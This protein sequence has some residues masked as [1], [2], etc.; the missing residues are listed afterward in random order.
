MFQ[1]S[2]RSLRA[3]YQVLPFPGTEEA[4]SPWSCLP[5]EIKADIIQ[6]VIGLQ[7]LRTG[8]LNHMAV[9]R[10]WYLLTCQAV[11]ALV[12]AREVEGDFTGRQLS[13]FPNLTSLELFTNCLP[14]AECGDAMVGAMAAACPNLRRLRISHNYIDGGERK[15]FTE[16][17]LRLLFE[18][19][20][21]LE[22]LEYTFQLECTV[23]AEIANLTRLTSLTLLGIDECQCSVLQY[24]QLPAAASLSRLQSLTITGWTFDHPPEGLFYPGSALRVLDV[25]CFGL[26]SLTDSFSSLQN[27]EHLHVDAFELSSLPDLSTFTG[28]TY[29]SLSLSPDVNPLAVL[30]PSQGLRVLRCNCSHVMREVPEAVSAYTALRDLELSEVAITRLPDSLVRLQGLTRFSLRWCRELQEIPSFVWRLPS[31]QELVLYDNGG[32]GGVNIDSL[33]HLT[34]LTYLE[35]SKIAHVPDGCSRLRCL[36]QLT[37]QDIKDD[38]SLDWVTVLTALTTLEVNRSGFTLDWTPL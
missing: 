38:C 1:V 18:G 24:I 17:S 20:S 15:D 7:P 5:L 10:E 19:C 6:R 35:L 36:Q 30:P 25:T 8:N 23:P 32:R 3:P 14:Q 31:L 13:A 28:L 12:L 22:E 27:L 29:L 37:L 33:P 26:K 34:G 11:Q 16:E 2:D 9:S 4:A 21:Q